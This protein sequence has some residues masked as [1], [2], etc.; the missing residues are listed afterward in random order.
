MGQRRQGLM[1]SLCWA[2]LGD[3]KEIL[4]WGYWLHICS[5][6]PEPVTFHRGGTRRR[7]LR[8]NNLYWSVEFSV[9]HR[10]LMRQGRDQSQ[11]KKS[12]RPCW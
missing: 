8:Q 3:T 1:G 10:V 5:T 11:N 6:E 9:T 4:W 2:A 7:I 12:K